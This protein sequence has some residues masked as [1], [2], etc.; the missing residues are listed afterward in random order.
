M[1]VTRHRRITLR[2][3]EDEFKLMVLIKSWDKWRDRFVEEK[4]RVLVCYNF[5]LDVLVV[6]SSK[7]T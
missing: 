4:L 6:Y 1:R 3:N 5:C 2:E 7:G